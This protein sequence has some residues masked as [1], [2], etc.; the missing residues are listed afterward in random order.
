[1]C[2]EVDVEK[3]GVIS[4]NGVEMVREKV[5]PTANGNFLLVIA[6][7]Y[8]PGCFALKDC[9]GIY[10]YMY[11]YMWYGSCAVPVWY[12]CCT[13]VVPVLYQCGTNAIPVQY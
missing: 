5:T 11:M 4:C 9:S 13:S 10:M 6:V 1:M 2:R 8:V 3:E 12:Q 7:L